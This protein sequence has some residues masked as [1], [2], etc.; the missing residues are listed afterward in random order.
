[1]KLREGVR[2][3]NMTAQAI[4]VLISGAMTIAYGRRR[5]MLLSTSHAPLEELIPLLLLMLMTFLWMIQNTV[6]STISALSR[7]LLI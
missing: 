5:T 3:L 1:M 7:T 6:V 2:S 4:Q